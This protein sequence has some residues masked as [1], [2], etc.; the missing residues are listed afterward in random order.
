M[1]FSSLTDDALCEVA[2]GNMPLLLALL[3]TCRNARR[4][5]SSWLEM[6]VS[7]R[8][9]HQWE[10]TQR[11]AEALGRLATAPQSRLRDVGVLGRSFPVQ[12]LLHDDE[13]DFV[14]G[15]GARDGGGEAGLDTAQ[16]MLLTTSPYNVPLRCPLT[17]SPYNV[18]LQRPLIRLRRGWSRRSCA[19]TTH[20]SVRASRAR[21][22]C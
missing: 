7:V 8:L 4:V 3:A 22:A 10:S 9:Q 12:R 6:Q 1:S 17:T 19:P 11:V 14:T 16:A 20:F 13:L 18:P 2:K 15:L 21:R 5:L